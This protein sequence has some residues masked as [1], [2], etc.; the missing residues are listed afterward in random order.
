[1]SRIAV[2]AM[3]RGLSAECIALCERVLAITADTG[4]DDLR[5]HALNTRGVVRVDVGDMRGLADLEESIA[6]AERLNAADLMIRGYKNHASVLATLGEIE[7][8]AALH[9]RGL[10]VSRRFG[11]DYQ[12]A[13][14]D[15]EL[16]IDAYLTGDWDSA[17]AAF[18]RLDEWVAA[19]GPHY[20]E[21][22]A[23]SSRS[24]LR[25]ARGDV[26]GA[27]ADIAGALAFARRSRDPQV[28]YPTLADAALAA[29]T[30]GGEGAAAEVATLMDEIARSRQPG[31][32]MR[33]GD[34]AVAAAAAAILTDQPERFPGPAPDDASHWT[35]AAQAITQGRFADAATA[36]AAIG[37]RTDEAIARLLAG[38]ALIAAGRPSEGEVELRRAIAFWQEVDAAACLGMAEALLART[39]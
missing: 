27:R 32:V 9:R 19:V 13:W 22:G 5:S 10:E 39:D 29:A 1:M 17:E 20:I 34:W 25:S 2:N 14:F 18:A 28:L 23:H 38:R 16:G 6:I 8:A 21:A 36:L 31:A 15:A 7:A 26:A 35:T 4:L 12:I 30:G 33:F 11:A 24:R 3:L 37:A